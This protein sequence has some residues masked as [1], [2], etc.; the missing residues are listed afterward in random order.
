MVLHTHSP[1]E[2]IPRCL[3]GLAAMLR[4]AFRY[5]CDDRAEMFMMAEDSPAD[6]PHLI[7]P[8]AP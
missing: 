1:A 4:E 5:A 3:E 2:H 7:A 8:L 6:D